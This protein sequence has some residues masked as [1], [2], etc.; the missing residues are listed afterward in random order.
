MRRFRGV[1]VPSSQGA[2]LNLTMYVPPA[3][4]PAAATPSGAV[5]PYVAQCVSALPT[6]DYSTAL[7]ALY[8][9]AEGSTVAWSVVAA[10]SLN[11]LQNAFPDCI[12]SVCMAC[13][14]GGTFVVEAQVD[15]VSV[16]TI[17]VQAYFATH[18]ETCISLA[19]SP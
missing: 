2:G 16:G 19:S 18:I 7:L 13:W 9:L 15:G 17:D 14:S 1:T 6:G 4:A 3:N 10:D 5:T 11:F 8:G 12:D